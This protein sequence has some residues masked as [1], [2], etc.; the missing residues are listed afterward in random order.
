MLDML[1]V[2]TV[3]VPLALGALLFGIGMVLSGCCTSGMFIRVAEGYTVHIFTLIAVIAGYLFANNHYNTVWA[4]WVTNTPAIFLPEEL[5]WELGI[6][7]HILIVFL[8][9]M[10]AHKHEQGMSSSSSAT[11]L[12]GALLL[13]GLN[14]LHCFALES[15]WTVTG[16]FFWIG[17]MLQGFGKTVNKNTLIHGIGPNLQNLGLFVGAG[18]SV[19]LSTQFKRQKIR[20]VK[21]VVISMTGGLFMGYGACIAGGCIVSSFFTAAAALS[22]SA[23]VYMLCLFAGAFIGTKILYKLL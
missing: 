13:G 19:L 20:S 8:L 12:I 18:I 7:I 10:V 11:L 22:L 21:Q 1:G 2:S 4:P 16:A 3:S 6:G 15:G 14:I 9:Y 17:E 23:W 5:G